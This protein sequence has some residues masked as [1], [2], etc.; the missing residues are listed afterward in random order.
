MVLG[1]EL[2]KS[3]KRVLIDGLELERSRMGT[4]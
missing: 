4:N 2:R 1:F 3:L